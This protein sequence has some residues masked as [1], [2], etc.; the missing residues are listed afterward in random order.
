MSV[1]SEVPYASPLNVFSGFYLKHVGLLKEIQ[2]FA[3]SL[4]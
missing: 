4:L 3:I 1:A 2:Q